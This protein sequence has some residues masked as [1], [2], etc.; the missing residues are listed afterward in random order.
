MTTSSLLS[1]PP[2]RITPAL[3]W[4][5]KLLL[6]LID[7]LV[8]LLI[9]DDGRLV[10]L[11]LL[12]LMNGFVIS[13]AAIPLVFVGESLKPSPLTPETSEGVRGVLVSDRER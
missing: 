8:A 2:L 10:L 13:P 5:C 7:P 12:A 6:T 11:G 9:G 1:T 4:R 3:A